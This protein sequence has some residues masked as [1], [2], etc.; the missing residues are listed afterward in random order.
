LLIWFVGLVFQDRVSLYSSG[1]PET[2]FVGLEL[3][4]PPASA[5]QNESLNH[6]SRLLPKG[7]TY[8][9]RATPKRA[10]PW[11]KHI[12][13]ITPWLAKMQKFSFYETWSH[14]V[15][16]RVTGFHKVRTQASACACT[17]ITISPE[18]LVSY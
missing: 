18:E 14:K 13:T 9:N 1:F 7:H 11:A 8:S 3:R 4:N 10:T 5:S 16:W 2:H 17:R 6:M 15:R 12:Q